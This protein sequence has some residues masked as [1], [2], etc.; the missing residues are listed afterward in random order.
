[1]QKWLHAVLGSALRYLVKPLLGPPWPVPV[2][3]AWI[4][5]VTR[6]ML[7]ARGV[8]RRRAGCGGIPA[9]WLV[10]RQPD[11]FAIL[12][13]H[14]GAYVLGSARTHRSITTHLARA[15]NA[16]V[17][18]VDY[19]LAPEHP[20]PAALDDAL[21]AYGALV[22][23]FGPGRV[24]IAGDSAGG[25]L[26]MATALA[27]RD[28]G[29]PP[30]HALAVIAPW[31]DLT[32]SGESMQSRAARDPMLR[33]GWT[34]QAAGCY[35]GALAHDDPRLSPLFADLHDLPPLLIQVGS[36]EILYSDAERLDERAR[37]AGVAVNFRPYAGQ[38]HVFHLHA[39]VLDVSDRAIQEIAD[40]LRAA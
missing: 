2:Q 28:R 23:Q 9:E 35:A 40:F 8:Q 22:Q 25:G 26:T 7:S 17:V 1:M 36:E 11:A 29:L 20:Y 39:G 16:T 33:I 14:G 12:F 4:T 24:A 38:W 3:R 15:A 13:L 5:G 34:R 6:L 27:I 10:P 32:A 37:A 30:P 21:A 19:R 18:A 31:V